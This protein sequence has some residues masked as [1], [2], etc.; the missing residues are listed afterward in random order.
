MAKFQKPNPDLGFIDEMKKGG[1]AEPNCKPGFKWDKAVSKSSEG[2]VPN[3][4]MNKQVGLRPSSSDL[5]KEQKQHI[6]KR[7]GKK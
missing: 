5:V 2:S 3:P 1:K 6:F 7:Q 4:Q